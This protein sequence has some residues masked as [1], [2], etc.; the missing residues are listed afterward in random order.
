MKS[1]NVKH[2]FNLDWLWNRFLLQ[3]HV[4]IIAQPDP[5]N[6]T[7]TSLSKHLDSLVGIKVH[8]LLS[9]SGHDLFAARRKKSARRRLSGGSVRKEAA[10]SCAPWL[11][12]KLTG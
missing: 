1:I 8:E 2:N 11:T 5:A 4:V 7:Q 9:V 10:Y 6:P 3:G 12:Q